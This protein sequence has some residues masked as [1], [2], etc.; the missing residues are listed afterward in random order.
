M[1]CSVL[2]DRQVPV[3]TTDSSWREQPLSA[4][5]LVNLLRELWN[6]LK[7]TW[8]LSVNAPA[9][10][11]IP[12]LLPNPHADFNNDLQLSWFLTRSIL[13][14]RVSLPQAPSPLHLVQASLSWIRLNGLSLTLSLKTLARVMIFAICLFFFFHWCRGDAFLQL[15]IIRK[16]NTN[17]LK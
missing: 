16:K 6:F 7:Q 15:H 1:L 14:D 13:S 11:A 5:V 9:P 10:S 3:S 17:L 2:T 8:R 4:W 12:D